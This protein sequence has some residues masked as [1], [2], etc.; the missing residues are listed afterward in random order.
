MCQLSIFDKGPPTPCPSPF[1]LAAYVLAQ[2]DAHRDK[3]AL[4]V[5]HSADKAQEVWRYSE[6]IGAVMCTAGGLV[7]L[8]I[9][10]GE[11]V[12]LRIGNT[13]DFPILFLAIIVMG[14][15]PVPTSAQLT[16]P[17]VR[18]II[19]E[20]DPALVC[21]SAGVAE[22]DGLPCK[23][24]DQAGVR[25]LRQ[26]RPA[27]ALSCQP[28]DLAYIIYTSGTS[29]KPRAVM[30]AHRAVWARRMMWQG[31]YGLRET[32]RMLHAG[33]FN[34]TYTLG[35]GLLDPWAIGGTSMI[36]TG[37]PDR[38]IWAQL[39]QNHKP[40]IFAAAPGVYRQLLSQPV[41]DKFADL[42]HGLSAGE[43]LPKL[44]HNRWLEAT[45]K[46]IYEALG[47]SEVS[48]FISTGP[49]IPYQTGATGKPQNGRS[50]AVV[51]A[52]GPVRT[53]EPG[54]LAV[55]R[56]DQGLMLGYRDQPEETAARY[57]GDWFLTGDTVTMDA[58]GYVTYLGRDDDM[59]NA[60]G[61]RV[62]P[63]EVENVLQAHPNILEAAA[64][65]YQAK[66]E[67]SIIAAF[68]VSEDNIS[69]RSLAAHC[70]KNLARYK[71]PRIFTRLDALP[72]GANNKLLRANLRNSPIG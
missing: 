43:K 15:V 31:W 64:V 67:T 22:L 2:A 26:S 14:A 3:P 60:G 41:D 27:K 63:L 47:M 4:E 68:Y 18:A 51:D 50:I 13:P 32:D 11:R 66:S 49:D 36:Y 61:Y 8:G 10:P 1:N 45:G 58:Q 20:L 28:D 16:E 71:C 59:I 12:L 42:R 46:P 24:L 40:T 33:A 70:A 39:S 9:Q 35:T 38:S 54:V 25:A 5:Y 37:P 55:S 29:G 53:G 30:H 6:L 19:A 44:L 69:E 72:K 7:G 65:E 23:S 17:E 21:F 52:N 62:S 48:T 57:Q 34:W 56:N